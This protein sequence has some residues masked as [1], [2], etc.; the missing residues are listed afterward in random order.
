MKRIILA[1]LTAL[2]PTM[3]IALSCAPPDAAQMYLGAAGSETAYLPV[4]GQ[5]YAAQVNALRLKNKGGYDENAPK[6]QDFPGLRFSG[7]ALTRNGFTYDFDQPIT[8]RLSC[9][10]PWCPGRPGDDKMLA[11]LEVTPEGYRLNVNACGGMTMY[12]PDRAT[13]K[14]VTTCHRGGACAPEPFE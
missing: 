1:F 7:K 8:L 9:I 3:S 6:T 4:H 5:F 14:R 13:L 2:F 10:G 11:Y 12:R